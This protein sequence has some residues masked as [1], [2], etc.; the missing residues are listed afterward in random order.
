MSLVHLDVGHQDVIDC[1]VFSPDGHRILSGSWDGTAK[2]WDVQSGALLKTLSWGAQQVNAVAWSP[3]G[4]R[5]AVAGSRPDSPLDESQ[6]KSYQ[7]YFER[8]DTSFFDSQKDDDCRPADEIRLYDASTGVLVNTFTGSG[9]GVAFSPDGRRLAVV[10]WTSLSIFDLANGRRISRR[11]MERTALRNVFYSD[12]GMQVACVEHDGVFVFDALTAEPCFVATDTWLFNDAAHAENGFRVTR[13][14]NP[15]ESEPDDE[16]ANMAEFWRRTLP[17]FRPNTSSDGGM[18]LQSIAFSPDGKHAA[19]HGRT[20]INYQ[21]PA[22]TPGRVKIL[23]MSNSETVCYLGSADQKCLRTTAFSPDGKLLAAAG[24]HQTI[25]VWNVE[26]GQEVRSIGHPPPAI[27]SVAFARSKSLVAAGATDGTL[28]LCDPDQPTVLA[29]DHES[30]S[31]VVHVEFTP[32]TQSLLVASRNG[33]VRVL[34]LPE[35]KPTLEFR[36]HDARFLGGAVSGDGKRFVSVGYADEPKDRNDSGKAAAIIVW[37]LENGQ[38]LQSKKLPDIFPIASVSASCSR[39]QLAISF[40]RS[41]LI[42]DTSNGI[43]IQFLWKKART[44]IQRVAFGAD[45]VHLLVAGEGTRMKM[46][47]LGEAESLRRFVATRAGPTSFAFSHDG[48][49]LVRSTAYFREIE[50]FEVSTGILKKYF[51]GHQAAVMS[52]AMSPDN[53]SLASGGKDGTPKLW[54]VESAALK[55]SIVTLPNSPD[56]HQRWQCLVK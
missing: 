17:G 53:A 10:S 52:L 32:D 5:V 20:G 48:N 54:D 47:G 46:I 50:L 43:R 29:I 42:A 36:C 13:L 25:I 38:K 45:D 8:R 27:I 12:D 22:S 30:E 34:S 4:D 15:L 31:P 3:D 41:V 11:N 49:V 28:L 51:L 26:T 37:S 2:L 19:I 1:L 7:A 55:A 39:N 40:W 9:E 33:R 18:E 16:T 35:L 23:D 21:S 6:L 14:P 56:S 24:D 44:A